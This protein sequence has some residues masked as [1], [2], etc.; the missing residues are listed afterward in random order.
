MEG[1]PHPKETVDFGK[2]FETWPAGSAYPDHFFFG[3]PHINYYE[4]TAEFD[5]VKLYLPD[6]G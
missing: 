6:D 2:T 5:D 4:G 3:D 1:R